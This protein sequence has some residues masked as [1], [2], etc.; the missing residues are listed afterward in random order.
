MAVKG[1]V[2]TKRDQ[3]TFS[4]VEVNDGSCMKG[5][6]VRLAGRGLSGSEHAENGDRGREREIESAARAARYGVC[7]CACVC[8][9]GEGDR[10]AKVPR[11]GTWQSW[12]GLGCAIQKVR[13]GAGTK[14]E[15]LM[16][17]SLIPHTG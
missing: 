15:D 4:F 7:V 1:W 14:A 2:R 12:E 13:E 17:V 11:K 6:Q 3:K 8:V 16:D 9:F 5:V 10:N